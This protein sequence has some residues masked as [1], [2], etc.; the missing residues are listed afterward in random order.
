MPSLSQR[1][2]L[3][4]QA[5]ASGDGPRAAPAPPGQ[6]GASTQSGLDRFGQ[7]RI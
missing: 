5:G 1:R 7:F 3:K 2:L 4:E 6:P